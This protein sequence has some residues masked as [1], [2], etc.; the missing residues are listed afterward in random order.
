[1]VYRIF[2]IVYR[3]RRIYT[4]TIKPNFVKKPTICTLQRREIFNRI[5]WAVRKTACLS[6][7]WI[8][9]I[10]IISRRTFCTLYR[11]NASI[12][13]FRTDITSHFIIILEVFAFTLFYTHRAFMKINSRI[14]SCTG[15]FE[16]IIAF[17]ALRMT[18]QTEAF[19]FI[20]IE[21]IIWAFSYTGVILI[22]KI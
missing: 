8:F 21:S 7:I 4:F 14:T 1:M 20:D 11:T 6:T 22:I 9:R 16:F 17:V 15:D 19:N 13:L 18:R 3:T 12:A 10:D 5:P 2:G